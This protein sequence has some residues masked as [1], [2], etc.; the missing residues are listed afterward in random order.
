VAFTFTPLV[1]AMPVKGSYL[2]AAGG[3]AIL[4]WSGLRGKKWSNVVRSLISGH[5]IT[6]TTE[7]P[8]T[9]SPAA[10]TAGSQLGAGVAASGA[11]TATGQAIASDA[12]SYE[13]S[14]YTWGGVPGAHGR[15]WDCSSFV[16]AVVGRDLHLAIPM[17]KAGAYNG[18]SHGPV[19][20]IW[21]IWPGCFT[22]KRQ[23]AAPGDIVVWPTHMGIVI[24]PGQMISAY[25]TARGTTTTSISGGGP[26]GEVY[27][28]RRLKA[29]TARG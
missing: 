10:Y 4:L 20:G 7:L 24:G 16:N 15:T 6:T 5:P 18:Q 23:D 29:V 9:T 19:T 1:L 12:M 11:L 22:I 17:Y 21:L 8:I 28:I 27:V 3:G 14:G 13:G 25:D 26:T 2:I